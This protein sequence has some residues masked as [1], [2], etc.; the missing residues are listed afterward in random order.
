MLFH[1]SRD[2]SDLRST[3][4][5]KYQKWGGQLKISNSDPSPVNTIKSL[6]Q[7]SDR[8]NVKLSPGICSYFIF[9]VQ[10]K[11]TQSE[12][13]CKQKCDGVDAWIT[14]GLLRC[15][16]LCKAISET[17]D[18]AFEK[19]LL[20]T[21]KITT[22]VSQLSGKVMDSASSLCLPGENSA[23][24]RVGHPYLSLDRKFMIT[25]DLNRQK[26]G[27]HGRST[28]CVSFYFYHTERFKSQR[29]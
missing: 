29:M 25:G 5:F 1:G 6:L 26:I 14:F 3:S 8:A 13:S 17:G 15:Y 19:Q 23:E 21:L 16:N 28:I 10:E 9:L 18:W 20:I 11:L 24:K 27:F 7:D 22:S 2:A 4:D 12:K